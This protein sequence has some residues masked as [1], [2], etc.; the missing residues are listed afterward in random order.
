MDASDGPNVD[1]LGVLGGQEHD[2]GCPVPS[3]H[4]VV[5]ERRVVLV[6]TE[7]ARQPEVADF[8]VAIF[9]HQYIG[10][11]QIAMHDVA[12]VQVKQ[13]SED[14]VREVLVVLVV[15]HLLRV[16]DAVQ[17]GFHEISNYVDVVEIRAV[18]RVHVQDLDDVVVSEAS[19][20]L[21][22]SQDPLAVDQVVEGIRDLFHSK[23]GAS[24]RIR[25]RAHCAIR[26]R[27]NLLDQLQVS[28]HLELHLP[29]DDQLLPLRHRSQCIVPVRSHRH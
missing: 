17:V 9:V 25:K 7:A 3:R 29:I 21:D 27:S 4:D 14:L 15:E 11:L 23:L 13:S 12:T 26:S 16:D 10:G 19:Q 20:Q 2:L 1:G 8:Q 18:R 22:L 6:A 24:F 5:R 28:R